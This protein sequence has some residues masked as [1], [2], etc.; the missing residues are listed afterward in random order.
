LSPL[1]DE[2]SALPE[3]LSYV[4]AARRRVVQQAKCAVGESSVQVPNL[5][6]LLPDRR[7]AERLYT[8]AIVRSGQGDVTVALC[9]RVRRIAKREKASE[10]LLGTCFSW[11]LDALLSLGEPVRAMALLAR[12]QHDAAQAGIHL[13]G[14]IEWADGYLAPV[15][16]AN[17]RFEQARAIRERAL[18][19]ALASPKPHYFDL[20]FRIFNTDP[21]PSHRARVTLYHILRGLGSRLSAWQDWPRF[22]GGLNPSLLRLAQVTRTQLLNNPDELVRVDGAIQ[23]ERSRR[24]TSGITRG[25]SDLTQPAPVVARE[26]AKLAEHIRQS[27]ERTASSAL[28]GDADLK[29]FFPFLFH[30]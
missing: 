25:E 5:F 16:Y 27:R 23:V 15:L 28:Q 29:Q 2:E 3:P 17:Q 21:A 20:L 9:R 7:Y 8:L 22:V 10:F 1:D 14:D 24:V 13:A 4:Q 12:Y 30:R 11:E 19:Q 18:A 26:Q 6:R